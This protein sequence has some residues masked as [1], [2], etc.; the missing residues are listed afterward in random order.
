MR[1]HV[2]LTVQNIEQSVRFYSTLFGAQPAL[3]KDDYAK[4]ELTNPPLHLAVSTHGA[5]P[6]LDHLGIQLEDL[7]HL[8]EITGRLAFSSLPVVEQDNTACCY[9]QSSK[10]WVSDPAGLAWELFH[11]TSQ[12]PTYGAADDTESRQDPPA[13]AQPCCARQSPHDPA[14]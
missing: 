7:D 9:A 13:A 4:W 8:R 3:L 10:T 2:N 12:I 5:R 14:V 11:T 1:L 6:G